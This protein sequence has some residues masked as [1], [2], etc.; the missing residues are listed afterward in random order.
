MPS[1]TDKNIKLALLCTMYF[2]ESKKKIK[3]NMELQKKNRL[4][5]ND[6]L[7]GQLIRH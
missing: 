1:N 5:T 3:I 4:T 7:F 6:F 2:T